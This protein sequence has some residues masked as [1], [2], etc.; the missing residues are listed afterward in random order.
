MLMKRK[1]LAPTS[2]D[3]DKELSEYLAL[4]NTMKTHYYRK[5]ISV[6]LMDAQS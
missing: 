3:H 6:R 1:F 5:K 2:L 4:S